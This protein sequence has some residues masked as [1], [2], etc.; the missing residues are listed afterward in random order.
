MLVRVRMLCIRE[1]V[2]AEVEVRLKRGGN[3][4]FVYLDVARTATIRSHFRLS[5]ARRR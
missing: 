5:S 2:E 4:T 3:T 1:E